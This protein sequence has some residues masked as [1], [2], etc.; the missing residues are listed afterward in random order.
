MAA[1]VTRARLG[2]TTGVS[3]D[4]RGAMQAQRDLGLMADRLPWLQERSMRT[5][6]RR[7][8]VEARRDIRKEYNILAGRVRE[9][10]RAYTFS[11]GSVRLAGVRLVAQWKRGIGL[12]QFSARPTRRGVTYAVYRGRGRSLMEGAFMARLAGARAEGFIGPMG[13][14][15][16]HAVE[17][18][19]L[20]SDQRERTYYHR[21]KKTG[22]VRRGTR[23]DGKL[24]VLY[25]STVAQ[26]LAN[27]RRPE[28]LADYSRDVLREEV[29]RQLAS[30]MRRPSAP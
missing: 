10:M 11:E 27:G 13:R 9:H 19:P 1:T 22:R 18:S 21:D 17:R 30:Y 24:I 2:R 3:F 12:A 4:L 7:L 23:T 14:G 5:L 6:A 15:N 26:M 29:E 25:R 16:L 20:K 28:K 8:P